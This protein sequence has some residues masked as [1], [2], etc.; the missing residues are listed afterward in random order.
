MR[1]DSPPTK[2]PTVKAS[3]PAETMAPTEPATKKP[4]PLI[5]R[6]T[7]DEFKLEEEIGEYLEALGLHVQYRKQDNDLIL[8]L[9]YSEGFTIRIDT[10]FTTDDETERLVAI[11]LLTGMKVAEKDLSLVYNQINAHHV[12][13]WAGTFFVDSDNE[14][15]G[16]WSINIPAADLPGALVD[17]AMGRLG[18]SWVA[19]RAAIAKAKVLKTM[20]ANPKAASEN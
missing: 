18:S 9:G 2:T 7:K 6:V 16:Q 4:K 19:L 10:W 12:E 8:H 14:I 20:D 3:P 11:R 13:Y 15:R 17:D 1:V 5:L